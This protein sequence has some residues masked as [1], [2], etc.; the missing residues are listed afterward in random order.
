MR[1]RLKREKYKRR[2][3][4]GGKSSDG[5][6]DEKLKKFLS[7]NSGENIKKIKSTIKKSTSKCCLKKTC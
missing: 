2:Q 3:E 4:T 5:F 7:V 1:L 6:C